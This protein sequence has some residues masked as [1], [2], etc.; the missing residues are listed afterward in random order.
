MLAK[1]LSEAREFIAAARDSGG[2]C[3]VHCVAGINRS[4]VTVAAEHM[5][6][7]RQNVLEVVAHCRKQRGNVFLSN[8]SFQEELVALARA[9]DLLGPKP[10][11]QGCIVKNLPQ[12]PTDRPPAQGPLRTLLDRL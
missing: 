8:K 11:E 2:K 3:V 4:G 6:T 1:H 7:T 10:G 5:L 9:H 12:K